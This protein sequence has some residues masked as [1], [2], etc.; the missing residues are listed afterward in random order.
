MVDCGIEFGCRA[1]CRVVGLDSWLEVF[2][3]IFSG[4][5]CTTEAVFEAFCN[6]FGLWFS[7]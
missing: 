1:L 6:L 5:D 4:V 3:P 2:V 7:C